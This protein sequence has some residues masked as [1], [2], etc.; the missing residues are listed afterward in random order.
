VKGAVFPFNRFDKTDT[1]LGPEMRS[2]GEV[3]GRAPTFGGAFAKSLL[4]NQMKLPRKGNVFVSVRD[5][6]KKAAL[7]ACRDLEW[8]GLSL[9][10]TQGTHDF[11]KEHGVKSVPV[12]KFQE[13]NPNCVDMLRLREFVLVVNTTSDEKAVEDSYLIRRT[14]LE[15]K[16]PCLTTISELIAFLKALESKEEDLEVQP[17]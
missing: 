7:G 1:I 2:T 13:G 14:A 3:M 8:H 11:L 5:E 17:L 6:D 12:K 16:I 9:Y 4:G 15:S 10:A